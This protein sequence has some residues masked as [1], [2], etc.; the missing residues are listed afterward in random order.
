MK[1]TLKIMTV[2]L[3]SF[4]IYTSKVFATSAEIS[5]CEDVNVLKAF[6]IGGYLLYIAKILVPILLI[7][8]GCVD[9]FK[10]V[11]GDSEALKKQI[12]MFIKQCIAAV[13]VFLLPTIISFAFS[14]IPDSDNSLEKYE[15]C[16]TCLFEPGSSSCKAE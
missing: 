14:L 1:K 16:Q 6:Q 8:F 15:P 13:V 4:L 2:F 9:M 7:I 10:A 5:L 3:F 11:V 12:P